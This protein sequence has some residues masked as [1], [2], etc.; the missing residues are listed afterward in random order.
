MCKFQYFLEWAAKN[1]QM[2]EEIL[3]HE[4]NQYNQT[5]TDKIQKTDE[6]EKT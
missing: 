2:F 4:K 6:N 5:K 3:Q 1:H